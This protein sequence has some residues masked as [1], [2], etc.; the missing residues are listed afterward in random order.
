MD[1]WLL[2]SGVVP[3]QANHLLGTCSLHRS[4]HQVHD[5]L[6]LGQEHLLPAV[7]RPG[8]HVGYGKETDGTLLSVDTVHTSRPG[9]NRH[10]LHNN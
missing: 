4:P 5:Q 9:A 7:G 1:V 3:E 6:L 8:T 10:A 2:L